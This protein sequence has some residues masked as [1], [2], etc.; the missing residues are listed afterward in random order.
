MDKEEDGG[1]LDEPLLGVQAH[2]MD[3]GEAFPPAE[4]PVHASTEDIARAA[5]FD[6]ENDRRQEAM[7]NP[8]TNHLSLE[9]D[10]FDDDDDDEGPE[11]F[12]TI[13]WM[14]FAERDR[15]RTLHIHQKFKKK[16]TLVGFFNVAYHNSQGWIAL[17]II[18]F[19]S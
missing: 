18:G 8:H 10:E 12:S 11:D 3:D 9:E 7:K 16:P 19:I 4:R 6:E 13:D 1:L 5:S 14:T 15:E 17:L 2:A